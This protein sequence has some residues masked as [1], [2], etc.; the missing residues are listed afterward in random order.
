MLMKSN[1]L[2]GPQGL[3]MHAV[4]VRSAN[5]AAATAFNA[6]DNSPSSS[7]RASWK[8]ARE[9]E[10]KMKCVL[11]SLVIDTVP[12]TPRTPPPRAR[13][14]STRFQAATRGPPPRI[15]LPA[16]HDDHRR[17]SLCAAPA[18]PFCPVIAALDR[19][20]PRTHNVSGLSKLRGCRM[21]QGRPPIRKGRCAWPTDPAKNPSRLPGLVME[22][23][24]LLQG[25][26]G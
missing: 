13:C 20:M 24:P 17:A 15:P 25:L 4:S 16:S 23:Q 8:A 6:H 18:Q 21:D 3:R 14:T 19:R 12:T 22:S 1:S 10:V 11:D 2:K 7:S 5:P 9:V 26:R